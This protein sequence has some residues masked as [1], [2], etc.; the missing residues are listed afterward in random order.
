MARGIGMLLGLDDCSAIATAF[1]KTVLLTR[2]RYVLS[3]L[4]ISSDCLWQDWFYTVAAIAC[5]QIMESLLQELGIEEV[6]VLY[7]T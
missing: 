2:Q 6:C 1:A 3:S 4:G 5:L 7:A